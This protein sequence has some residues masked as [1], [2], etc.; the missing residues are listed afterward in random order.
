MI[1]LGTTAAN[2]MP[3]QAAL[4]ERILALGR[5]TIAVALRTPWDLAAYPSAR[6]YACSF[7]ILP[8]SIEALVA[9][10]FGE[11]EFAGR[12]PVEIGGLYS[13]GHGLVA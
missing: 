12:L 10:L 13:R 4:A 2:L 3:A 6:T 5:P 8:P 7:G 1:I 11:K 9:A